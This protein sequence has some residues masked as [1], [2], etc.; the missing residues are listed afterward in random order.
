M[1]SRKEMPEPL[2]KNKIGKVRQGDML[3]FRK[4]DKLVLA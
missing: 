3:S 2:I 1:P 4:N